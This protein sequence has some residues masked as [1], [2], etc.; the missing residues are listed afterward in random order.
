MLCRHYLVVVIVEN[1]DARVDERT[2]F[3]ELL[4]TEIMRDSTILVD[5]VLMPSYDAYRRIR[6]V[7]FSCDFQFYE[8]LVLGLLSVRFCC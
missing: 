3:E 6:L 4:E 2:L 1:T 7:R 8:V 5:K